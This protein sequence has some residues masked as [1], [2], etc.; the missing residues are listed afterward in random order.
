MLKK[1]VTS[2]AV[3]A[4]ALASAWA[5]NEAHFRQLVGVLEVLEEPIAEVKQIRDWWEQY[6]TTVDLAERDRLIDN[7]LRTHAENAFVIGVIG[8]VMKPVL[9]N[10]SLFNV[11]TEGAHGYDAFRFQP[12]HP[13]QF[14]FRG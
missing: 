1:L 13:E 11:P 9:V 10:K 5:Y 2:I 6:T 12:N 8:D 4:P 7:V 3:G 14:L